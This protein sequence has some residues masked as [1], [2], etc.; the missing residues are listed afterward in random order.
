M[1]ATYLNGCCHPAITSCYADMR[2]N[3]TQDLLLTPPSFC[4]DHWR[5]IIKMKGDKSMGFLWVTLWAS[6]HK[7]LSWSSSPSGSPDEIIPYSVCQTW[8][9]HCIGIKVKAMF[10]KFCTYLNNRG[11]YMSVVFLYDFK[12]SKQKIMARCNI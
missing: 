4:P 10:L 5:D 12:G 1:S 11:H 7:D 9:V 2:D 8:T 3:F 6:Y